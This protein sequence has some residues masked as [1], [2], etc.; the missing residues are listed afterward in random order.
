MAHTE[1]Q[2]FKAGAFGVFVQPTKQTNEST[3]LGVRILQEEV[4]LRAEGEAPRHH[5]WV[6]GIIPV[7][8]S[9]CPHC[10]SQHT[11]LSS[12]MSKQ[13]AA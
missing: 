7:P 2:S 9:A 10:G 6:S 13:T 3:T 4:S 11:H 5:E 1:C 12:V 8:S